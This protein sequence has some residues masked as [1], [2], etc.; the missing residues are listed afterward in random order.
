MS[1][2]W[3]GMSYA[4]AHKPRPGLPGRD[5]A[6]E[7]L[8]AYER[9]NQRLADAWRTPPPSPP[10]LAIAPPGYWTSPQPPNRTQ[11]L[12]PRS[13]SH[14]PPWAFPG[15]SRVLVPG[16]L[17]HPQPCQP[18]ACQPQSLLILP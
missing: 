9:R 5:S 4:R 1:E 14:P 3:K 18:S 11:G 8:S 12:P 7:S 16:N 17:R 10:E 15:G 6:D 2:A 13:W